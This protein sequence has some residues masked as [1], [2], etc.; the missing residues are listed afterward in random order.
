MQVECWA[1]CPEYDKHFLYAHD[2]APLKKQGRDRKEEEKKPWNDLTSAL[3]SSEQ[4]FP[5]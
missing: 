1:D 4:V 3:V 2:L 5:A